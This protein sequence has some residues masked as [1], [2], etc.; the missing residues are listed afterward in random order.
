MNMIVVTSSGK[1]AENTSDDIK[2]KCP[3]RKRI[4]GGDEDEDATDRS[5]DDGDDDT[6]RKGKQNV[7]FF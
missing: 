7:F 4:E 3:N 6:T 2:S 5:N 1:D